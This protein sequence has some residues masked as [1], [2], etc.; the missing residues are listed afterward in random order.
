MI[1]A[2]M[3]AIP[4]LAELT[5]VVG[6]VI[7]AAGLVGTGLVAYFDWRAKLLRQ[8]LRDAEDGRRAA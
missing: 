4:I 5:R 7:L 1:V 6:L 2:F 3:L 8:I